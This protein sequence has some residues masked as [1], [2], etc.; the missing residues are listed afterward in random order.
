MA[1]FFL[2]VLNHI[3]SH[4]F[5]TGFIFKA[6]FLR[7]KTSICGLNGSLIVIRST[8]TSDVDLQGLG[9]NIISPNTEPFFSKP[10]VAFT[11]FCITKSNYKR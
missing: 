5:L 3:L 2:M 10:N 4:S 8:V 7:S 11:S 6:K 9:L 1:F